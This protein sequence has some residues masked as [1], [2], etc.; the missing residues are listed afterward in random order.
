[1]F[2]WHKGNKI[3][4]NQNGAWTLIGSLAFV[5]FRTERWAPIDAPRIRY[6]M[7][8]LCGFDVDWH[9]F[10]EPKKKISDQDLPAD[11]TLDLDAV[12][13]SQDDL[14]FVQENAAYLKFLSGPNSIDK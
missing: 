1:M 2:Y 9:K 13:I 11:E 7:T 10:K 8:S 3:C 5:S 12:A 6:V 4:D 14:D